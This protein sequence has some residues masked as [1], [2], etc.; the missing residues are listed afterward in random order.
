MCVLDIIQICT[1]YPDEDSDRNCIRGYLQRGG[2]ASNTCTVLRQLNAESE[3]LGILSDL[4]EFQYL[5]KDC[6]KRGIKIVNCPRVQD[7]APFSSVILNQR[8]GTRTI[9]HASNNFPILTFQHFLKIQLSE[10]DWIHFEGRN[11]TETTQMIDRIQEYNNSNHTNN[12]CHQQKIT[13]SLEWEQ[14]DK[15]LLL[16]CAKK[17]DYIFL[18][19]VAAE[20]MGWSSSIEAVQSL[21]DLI[22]DGQTYYPNIICPWGSSKTAVLH[23]N[24]A[25]NLVKCDKIENVVDS[26]GAGDT[27]IAAFIYA[28][29]H[30][31]LEMISA[32]KYANKMAG[33]KIQQFGFDHLKHFSP[34]CN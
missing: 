16:L 26:L 1:D 29:H 19:R 32:T 14:C 28:I 30:L 6:I 20:Y 25:L 15:N 31:G 23:S 4:E 9:V 27:F 21:R 7:N 3:F 33:R 2:N 8:T 34:M 18:S 11:V 22:K 5:T 13:I 17:L 24:G 10:Y 12:N